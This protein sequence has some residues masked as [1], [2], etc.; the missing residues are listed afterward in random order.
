MGRPA[1]SLSFNFWKHVVISP[2][3]WDWKAS[4]DKGGYAVMSHRHK[5][6]RA[7]RSSWLLHHGEIPEGLIIR[8][9]CDNPTC[10]NPRHLETGSVA[11]NSQDMIERGRSLF[12]SKNH[13]AKITE[14]DVL[15]IREMY[16]NSED[17]QRDIAKHFGI[18]DRSVSHIVRG[19]TW[20]KVG[21]PLKKTDR[22]NRPLNAAPT[23]P[24]V[25]ASTPSATIWCT[26]WKGMFSTR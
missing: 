5:T 11:D 22:N 23:S 18:N 8:H 9:R 15:K 13:K 25:R 21:G 19:L 17:S 26:R 6:M 14:V 24:A 3:C 2:G 12:G 1:S 4:T 16:A 20:R 10:T 7:H